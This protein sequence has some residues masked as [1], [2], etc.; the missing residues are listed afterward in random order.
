[1]EK[2]NKSHGMKMHSKISRLNLK[3][4][5][6]SRKMNDSTDPRISDIK[7]SSKKGVLSTKMLLSN[8]SSAIL[9]EISKV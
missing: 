4:Y 2:V 3:S 9:S 5:S 8:K 6:P 7:E 1:M